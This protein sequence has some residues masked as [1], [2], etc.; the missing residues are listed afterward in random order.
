MPLEREKFING[1]VNNGV[2]KEVAELVFKK[3]ETFAGYG[4]NLSHASAYA[5]IAY[6]CAH[7]KT[8]YPVEYMT[9]VLNS[10]I[11]EKPEKVAKYLNECKRMNIKILPPDI[12]NSEATHIVYEDKI[13]YGLNG[14]SAL[15][16]NGVVKI[17]ELRKKMKGKFNSFIEFF[18]QADKRSVNTKTIN[19]L[20]LTGCFDYL[21]HTRRSLVEYNNKLA[22]VMHT[23]T[24]RAGGKQLTVADIGYLFYPLYQLDLEDLNEYSI[25]E[26][27]SH[28]RELAGLYLSGHPLDMYWKQISHRVHC[29]SSDL[30][31]LEPKQTVIMGGL[32]NSIKTIVIKGGRTKGK[33]MAIVE[34][35]DIN[36]KVRITVFPEIYDK[37][38]SKLVEGNVVFVKGS[39]NIYNEEVGI[40]AYEV[41]KVNHEFKLE[42][43][44]EDELCIVVEKIEEKQLENL[45]KVLSSNR[46]NIK[47][48][49][50]KPDTESVLSI[51]INVTDKLIEQIENIEGVLCV[52]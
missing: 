17:F 33:T 9:S 14:I 16:E 47:V 36:G 6:Q 7:L 43:T 52:L 2:K 29:T 45:Y 51:R 32:V 4:F 31:E 50:L 12:N 11:G 19:N 34:L 13:L 35:E 24:S 30:D 1:C 38:K 49:L 3:I 44:I 27:L 22:E 41:E 21:G 25:E 48:R 18:L 5:M 20:I 40:V 8:Y 42:E 28:E 39:V 10:V 26:I 46:G 23:I 37:S 15:G